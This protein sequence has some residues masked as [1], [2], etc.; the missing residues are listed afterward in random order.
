MYVAPMLLLVKFSVA[1]VVDTPVAARPVTAAQVGTALVVKVVVAA[2]E[3]CPPP[4]FVTMLTV[5]CVF[6]A[7]PVRF[8][9]EVVGAGVT[10][11]AEPP[12]GV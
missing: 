10:V 8:T 11:V 6:G 5:Y 2:V 9:G 12:C 1:E 3:V 4:Q 7:R